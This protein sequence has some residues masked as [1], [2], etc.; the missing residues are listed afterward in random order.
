MNRI[1][2]INIKV[3]AL[4]MYSTLLFSFLWLS[5]TATYF[6]S[7]SLSEYM[8]LYSLLGYIE[9]AIGYILLLFLL[10]VIKKTIIRRCSL[11]I[12]WLLILCCPEIWISLFVDLLASKDFLWYMYPPT[13]IVKIV[14]LLFYKYKEKQDDKIHNQAP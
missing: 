2:N 14:F 1:K 9:V 3:L 12:V 13:I 8:Y 5:L 7:Y 11:F 4:G 10:Y 6:H